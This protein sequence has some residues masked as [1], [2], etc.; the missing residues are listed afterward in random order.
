MTFS[1]RQAP[2]PG[3]GPETERPVPP[4]DEVV[5]APEQK[6]EAPVV[7]QEPIIES[8]M[9]PEKAAAPVKELP[10]PRPQAD[11]RVQKREVK[12][13]P[14]KQIPE[15]DQRTVPSPPVETR[16]HLKETPGPEMTA[17]HEGAAQ[18][19]AIPPVEQK[20]GEHMGLLPDVP[21]L[22][23]AAAP[24]AEGESAPAPAAEEIVKAIPAYRD[25]PRP[26]YPRMAKRRGYEGTVLLEVLV[27]RGGRVEDLRII[28]SS[29]YD[30]LDTSAVKS[31]KG[32]L[33]EP[34]SIGGRKVDMWVRVPVRFELKQN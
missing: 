20:R 19:T 1:T 29:G 9:P 25:N 24:R 16:P 34:G 13:P 4:P 30:V 27:N 31:V 15:K 11:V 3:P 14:K 6:T 5:T 26:E 28:E 18:R 10:K 8:P 21:G 2:E 32:W 17:E 33:F 22:T 23:G 12:P 7:R